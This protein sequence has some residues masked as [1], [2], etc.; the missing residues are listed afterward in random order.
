[1]KK[2]KTFAAAAIFCAATFAGYTAY[3]QAT[4]TDSEKMILA[5]I[6]ALTNNGGEPGDLN[7]RLATENDKYGEVFLCCSDV[8]YLSYCGFVDCS[9]Y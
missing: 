2:I 3:N 6:E 5:N 7:H 8:D 4:M 9:E 1:M